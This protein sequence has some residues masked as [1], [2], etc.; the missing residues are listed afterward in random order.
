MT[1]PLFLRELDP[2]H[3][4]WPLLLLADP[5]REQVEGYLQRSRLLG[6]FDTGRALGVVVITPRE[7][8]TAEI[9]NLAVDEAWQGRGLGRRLLEAAIR[10]ARTDGLLRLTIATGNSSLA[11]LGLYQRVGFR[12]VGIEVDHFVRH[13][14][15][16]IYENGIQCRDQIRLVLDLSA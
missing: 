3:A 6:I 1:A 5:S 11:Q 16:P 7:Q 2:A 9:S 12:I 4:P 10:Q 8:G 14:P 15:E 13:Y